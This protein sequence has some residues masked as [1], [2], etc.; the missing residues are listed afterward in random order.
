MFLSLVGGLV[1]FYLQT[2]HWKGKAVA[3]DSKLI[4]LTKQIVSLNLENNQLSGKVV[5]YQ[6]ELE[7]NKQ[8]ETNSE[9]MQ[10]NLMKMETE[11]KEFEAKQNEMMEYIQELEKAN[12]QLS[13][14]NKK[15]A[16]P[17][18][19]I[20]PVKS[21]VVI[22]PVAPK[23]ETPVVTPKPSDGETANPQPQQP[24]TT[25]SPSP[26]AAD[27]VK[28]YEIM[29]ISQK[30]KSCAEKFKRDTLQKCH[31]VNKALDYE[32]GSEIRPTDLNGQKVTKLVYKCSSPTQK[33]RYF[34]YGPL[35]LFNT[36]K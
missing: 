1:H 15:P 5:N 35:E 25:Q 9:S 27:Q 23:A 36:C 12:D 19:N 24:A 11:R 26:K 30:Q 4:N 31:A 20:T 3:V 2:E 17:K 14:Q 13:K 34:K 10:E 28:D 7:N 22:P 21:S 18:K 29:M 6:K 33:T 32:L 16:L 8:I